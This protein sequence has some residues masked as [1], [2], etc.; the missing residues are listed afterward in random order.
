MDVIIYIIIF[1]VIIFS[2]SAGAALCDAFD[3]CDLS[4]LWAVRALSRFFRFLCR[5]LM[6]PAAFFY[7]LG[8]CFSRGISPLAASSMVRDFLDSLRSGGAQGAGD[9]CRRG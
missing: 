3:F 5:A 2:L 9:R 7:A 4:E 1:E 6:A 8:V